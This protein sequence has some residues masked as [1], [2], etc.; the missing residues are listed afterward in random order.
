MKLTKEQAAQN[1]RDILEAAGRL[2]RER[3]F[4]G[5]GVAD[6]MKEA[7]FTH[8][9]FY[10]HFPS[11][12]ALAAEM[13][14]GA[15]ERSN[16]KLASDLEQ[17]PDRAL[18]E[19]LEH[20]LSLEHR[21]D[22]AKGCTLAALAADTGRQPEEVQES[23]AKGVGEVFGLI[24]AHLAKAAP[25]KRKA[26]EGVPRERAIQMMSEVVGAVILARAVAAADPEL[27]AEILEANR[28]RLTG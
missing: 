4:D 6:L 8:G 27:S 16:S 20:Y 24:A 13:C 3:G 28:R 2:F 25:D 17:A 7:G 14:S 23:F 21:D 5:V 1:R 10:N 9:G 15:F 18:K 12:Q 11:K 26:G 19:F 22:P